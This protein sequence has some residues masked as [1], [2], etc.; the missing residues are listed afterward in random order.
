VRGGLTSGARL[1]AVRAGE[2]WACVGA[3]RW[4]AGLRGMGQAERAA[5]WPRWAAAGQAGEVRVWAGREREVG[6][7]L[8]FEFL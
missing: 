4:R 6:C 1:Q 2:R 8:G 7:G 3:G 5:A